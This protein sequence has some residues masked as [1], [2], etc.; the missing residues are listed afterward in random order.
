[1]KLLLTELNFQKIQKLQ[2]I[3]SVQKTSFKLE[4]KIKLMIKIPLIT[5]MTSFTDV[6]CQLRTHVIHEIVFSLLILN[7]YKPV[8][9][10]YAAQRSFP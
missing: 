10:A 5:S 1:M 7:M 2:T 8:Q 4:V 6:Y 3:P 9:I